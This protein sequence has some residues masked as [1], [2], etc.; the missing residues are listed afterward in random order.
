MVAGLSGCFQ[1]PEAPAPA[2][3]L[4]IDV[5]ATFP[6]PGAF[7]AGY[8]RLAELEAFILALSNRTL[9]ECELGRELEQVQQ[10]IA[11]GQH[12]NALLA[13]G[14]CGSKY[15]R[16]DPELDARIEQWR[17]DATE[18]ARWEALRAEAR[19]ALDRWIGA[20]ANRTVAGTPL[21]VEVMAA[22]MDQQM[23]MESWYRNG[24]RQRAD[25]N[26]SGRINSLGSSYLNL[27]DPIN[28][29][30]FG[31]AFLEEFPWSSGCVFD[32]DALDSSTWSLLERTITLGRGVNPE[33]PLTSIGTERGNLE[34]VTKPELEH[35]LRHDWPEAVLSI[36]WSLRFDERIFL[37]WD[38]QPL[39]T[40]EEAAYLVAKHRNETRSLYT[41]TL[42]LHH[43]R[44]VEGAAEEWQTRPRYEE[45]AK[46][47]LALPALRP[48]WSHVTCPEPAPRDGDTDR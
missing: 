29:S 35:A 22:L 39:P 8:E 12:R 2:W 3:G 10:S 25:Y 40:A 17:K 23:S 19:A 20:F 43:R 6:P 16:N 46:A 27:Y 14:L 30:A 47:I 1:A 41:D 13:G 11:E 21:E 34:L 7:P 37:Q 31:I 15:W 44:I 48:D 24:L 33:D 26:A 28:R 5:P 45:R 36:L 9:T 18:P 32:K 38:Q 4:G 42:N